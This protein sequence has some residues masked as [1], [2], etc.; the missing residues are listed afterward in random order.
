MDRALILQFTNAEQQGGEM[1]QQQQQQ[2]EALL[3]PSVEFWEALQSLRHHAMPHLIDE[4]LENK[5]IF[6]EP[7][8]VKHAIDVVD[9]YVDI[10][11][12]NGCTDN[13]H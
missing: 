13:R 8:T 7:G 3:Y 4:Y 12:R 2:Q 10:A 6:P 11:I 5:D 1:K 9:F